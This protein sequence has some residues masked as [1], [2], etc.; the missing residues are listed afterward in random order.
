M[1]P[2]TARILKLTILIFFILGNLKPLWYA[3]ALD[4]TD[5]EKLFSSVYNI[6]FNLGTDLTAQVTQKVSLKNLTKD[7]FASE[8]SL[9]INTTK[10]KN[11]SGRDALGPLSVSTKKSSGVVTLTA[12]L[13]EEVVGI[14]RTANF[15]LLYQLENFAQKEGSIYSFIVPKISAGEKITD[16]Q[17]RI[18]T[19]KSFGALFSLEPAPKASS[20]TKNGT[21]LVYDKQILSQDSIS[22][23]FG[24]FQEV[25]FDFSLQLENKNIFRKKFLIPLPPDTEKQQLLLKKLE[26]F[27]DKIILDSYGN[28]L[29][30]YSVSPGKTQAVTIAGSVKI[31]GDKDNLT[32]AKSFAEKDLDLWRAESMFVPVQDRLIQEKASELKTPLAIYNFVANS[33]EFAATNQESGKTSRQGALEVLQKNSKP[34]SFEF[35]DLFTALSRANGTPT[36]EAV[37]VTFSKNPSLPKIF[38]GEPLN[39][40]NLHLWAQIFDQD[41]LVW[42]NVD[43][44]Y[45]SITGANYFSR[46]LPERFVLLFSPSV[47]GLDNLKPFT[48]VTETIS[49][50][51]SDQ[52]AVFTPN[53]EIKLLVDQ[54]VA[55]FPANLKVTLENKAGVAVMNGDLRVSVSKSKLIGDSLTEVRTLL[56]FEKK[57]I[58]YKMRGG[59]LFKNEEGEVKVTFDGNSGTEKV[60]VENSLPFRINALFSFGAQQLLLITMLSLIAVG[61]I[62]PKIKK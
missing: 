52:K 14:N 12:K 36:R 38:L 7:C 53:V 35:V 10:V 55:G 31:L 26:P 41:T 1:S 49:T 56:P 60:S 29:A 24:S 6:T 11:V 59:E 43:P 20:Y 62:L 32:P 45:A 34:N 47:E 18:S 13:N 25:N 42:L 39:S 50:S 9:G 51:F 54:A 2:H 16:Y 48:L 28:Y 8:Y 5:S 58:T 46:S 17:L 40:K 4:C 22:A 61:F 3:H 57:V 27:P 19:P 37:G 15:T 30:Q 44:T 23:S 33:L 21:T